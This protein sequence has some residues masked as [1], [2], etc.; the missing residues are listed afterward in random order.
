MFRTKQLVVVNTFV[1]TI[2]MLHPGLVLQTTLS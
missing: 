1:F 2:Q